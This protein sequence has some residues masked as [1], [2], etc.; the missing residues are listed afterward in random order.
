MLLALFTLLAASTVV[1]LP[2]RLSRWALKT[3]ALMV[4]VSG[5]LLSLWLQLMLGENW[6]FS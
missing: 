2:L 3:P 4:Y 1:R 6:P 5:P